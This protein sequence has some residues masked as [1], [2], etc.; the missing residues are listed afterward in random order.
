MKQAARRVVAPYGAGIRLPRRCAPR[1]DKDGSACNGA[2][3]RRALRILS[4]VPAHGA[5]GRRAL[6]RMKHVARHTGRDPECRNRCGNVT[7]VQMEKTKLTYFGNT[8]PTNPDCFI[9]QRFIVTFY[10]ETFIVIA[11]LTAN[12]A[13]VIP[14][15]AEITHL[16]CGINT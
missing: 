8:A 15:C 14:I 4:G 12:C 6:R 5:P 7:G 1:N 10:F 11:A 9:V 2:P 3:G 13:K 16:F